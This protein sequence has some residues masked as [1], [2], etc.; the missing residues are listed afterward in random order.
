VVLA[1]STDAAQAADG[2]RVTM[3]PD[4]M[5]RARFAV[6]VD[7]QSWWC[8]CC[9]C[10]PGGGDAGHDLVELCARWQLLGGAGI[11]RATMY[12]WAVRY[13]GMMV[14]WPGI[15]VRD[16]CAAFHAGRLPVSETA[17]GAAG[18]RCVGAVH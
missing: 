6:P 5:G 15:T 4:P 8:S 14:W 9:L 12:Q 13:R 2:V 10:V 17:A 3:Q 18:H 1:V 16:R 11:H 7:I